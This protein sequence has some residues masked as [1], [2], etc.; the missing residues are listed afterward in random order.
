MRWSPLS[1][2]T[3][4]IEPRLAIICDSTGR[5][6][7]LRRDILGAGYSS[8]ITVRYSPQTMEELVQADPDLVLLDVAAL[9]SRGLE[10][11]QAIRAAAQFDDLP[12]IMLT[13]AW[14]T[15]LRTRALELGVT[16]F[17]NAPVDPAELQPRLRNAICARAFLRR[18]ASVAGDEIAGQDENAGQ[19]GNALASTEATHLPGAQASPDDVPPSSPRLSWSSLGETAFEDLKRTSKIMIVD[20]EPI[21]VKV[22]RLFLA[23]E[24]YQR[25]LTTT[26]SR[27]ALEMIRRE[28]PDVLLLDIMMPE[29]SGLEI[30]QAVR[31][32]EGFPDLPVIVI[33]AAT[34]AA[35]KQRALELGAT[36]FLTKPVDSTEILP[37][38]RN[39]LLFKSQQDRVKRYA[40]ELERKVSRHLRQ[41]NR[42]AAAL[43]QA[44][45]LL[46]RSQSAARAADRAKSAFLATLSYEVRTPLTAM[47]GFAEMMLAEAGARSLSPRDLENLGII[48]RNGRHLVEVINA[49]LVAGKSQE[50]GDGQIAPGQEGTFPQAAAGPPA[51]AVP[52]P[53]AVDCRGGAESPT[54]QAAPERL[55]GRILVAE[56]LIDNQRLISAVLGKAGAEVMVV[57]NGQEAVEQA[58]AAA[59]SGKP[60]D[61]VLMD[62][63]MP[64]LDGYAAARKLRD[65][66][67]SAPIVAVTAHALGGERE[68]CLA[69]GC[70]DYLSKPLSYQ[71]LT[72]VVA[73]CLPAASRRR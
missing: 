32:R 5:A 62:L 16:D 9:K 64:V 20:D 18:Q 14:E 70:D 2:E 13:S 63:Q 11:L 6:D 47:I 27:Q 22:V 38:V 21:N 68:K 30:L 8:V 53:P 43:E 57:G 34:D 72:G 40:Q 23:N 65:A 51:V 61:L 48:V 44:T 45:E 25:F 35:T 59:Q 50:A 56:D 73:R 52:V 12:V 17:L 19:D 33:T 15:P 42:Y 60:F 37:R 71:A 69:A 46:R 54:T 10:I 36:E 26:D 67:F 31:S 55:E 29:V 39:V 24:G 41:V 7:S 4:S 66:G 28:S 58:V 1:C 49:V 3:P